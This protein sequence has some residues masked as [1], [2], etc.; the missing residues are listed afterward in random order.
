MSANDLSGRDN[1]IDYSKTLESYQTWLRM[2]DSSLKYNALKTFQ[3][4]Q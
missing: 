2:V 4:L 1:T 3:T